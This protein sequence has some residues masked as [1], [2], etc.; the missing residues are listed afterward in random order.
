MKCPQCA[1]EMEKGYL[2]VRGLGGSLFWGTKK[3]TRFYSRRELQPI[4]LSK[5]SLTR[6]A[7]Q[8][9][10]DAAKCARCGVISFKAFP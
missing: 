9:V 7:A 6:P 5:L 1:N 2:Y 8:A 10:L 3:D 4:D